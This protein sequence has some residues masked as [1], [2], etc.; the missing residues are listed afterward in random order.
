MAIEAPRIL[1]QFIESPSEAIN[2]DPRIQSLVYALNTFIPRST[3]SSC[4]G[5]LDGIR[6]PYPWVLL[7]REIPRDE[8]TSLLEKFN[9]GTNLKW[10]FLNRGLLRP[11]S[12]TL[13]SYGLT[14]HLDRH[15]ALGYEVTLPNNLD[16]GVLGLLQESAHNLAVNIARASV[17]NFGDHENGNSIG[18]LFEDYSAIGI[19][20]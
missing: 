1:H 19:N 14:P 9:Y 8:L 5:H 13:A 4:E 18:M 15:F 6:Y 12:Q 7:H 17:S 16:L 11:S 2:F 3:Y 10:V 20:L